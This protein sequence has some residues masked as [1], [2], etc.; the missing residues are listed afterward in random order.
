MYI[1]Y[2][3]THNVSPMYVCILLMYLCMYISYLSYLC[4]YISYVCTHNVCPMNV[5]ILL[6]HPMY[7]CILLMHTQHYLNYV[8]ILLMYLMY[9]YILLLYP[10]PSPMFR[11]PISSA[12]GSRT[13]LDSRFHVL[14]RIYARMHASC[15]LSSLGNRQFKLFRGGGGLFE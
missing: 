10:T 4:M 12:R 15:A 2:V 5:C 1:S 13:E 3:C 9:L 14:L 11:I 7:V 6:M 8:C